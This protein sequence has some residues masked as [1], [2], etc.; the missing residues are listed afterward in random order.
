ME[1]D[2][3]EL[4]RLQVRYKTALEEW[5]GAIRHEEA[6]AFGESYRHGN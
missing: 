4:D 1:P 3:Q 2:T 5:V 6:L